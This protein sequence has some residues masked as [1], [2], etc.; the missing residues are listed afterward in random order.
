[1]FD[2][3]ISLFMLSM[4]VTIINHFDCSDVSI[5]FQCIHTYMSLLSLLWRTNVGIRTKVDI[6][7]G[8]WWIYRLQSGN[9]E[10]IEG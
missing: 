3:D 2:V 10:G 9:T 5:E 7:T 8:R 1:M 6:R 4:W